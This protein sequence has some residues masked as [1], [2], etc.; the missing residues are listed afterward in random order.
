MTSEPY[1]ELVQQLGNTLLDLPPSD[2]WRRINLFCK[3]TVSVQELGLTVI[4]NDGFT[5]AVEPPPDLGSIMA[6]IRSSTYDP[7]R[8]AWFSARVWLDPPTS[9]RLSYNFD[10]EPQWDP[11]IDDSNYVN[12]LKQFPRAP[13]RTPEWLQRKLNS[14][15]SEHS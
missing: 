8:G 12:D 14:A 4:M 1:D 9:I 10:H 13:H 5:P 3:A 6:K 15:G 7:E 11:P 2:D